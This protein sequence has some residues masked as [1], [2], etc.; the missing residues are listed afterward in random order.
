MVKVLHGRIYRQELASENAVVGLRMCELL[1]EGIMGAP[2]TV[3]LLLEDS[4]SSLVVEGSTSSD[5]GAS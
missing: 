1:G 4:P 3:N 5:V 2:K